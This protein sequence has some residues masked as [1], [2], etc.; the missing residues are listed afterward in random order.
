MLEDLPYLDKLLKNRSPYLRLSANYGVDGM[1]T[2][3]VYSTVSRPNKSRPMFEA[4]APTFIQA[5]DL[6]DLQIKQD[7]DIRQRVVD[8]VMKGKIE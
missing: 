2:V 7:E 3:Y 1:C 5:L 8:K 4:K 6:L